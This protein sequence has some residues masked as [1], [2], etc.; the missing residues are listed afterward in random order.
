MSWHFS[1]KLVELCENL[2]SSPELEEESSAESFWAGKPFAPW[3]SMPFAPDDSC[4]GKMRGI[5]H[6]SPFG[7]MFVP[8]TDEYGGAL[9]T[10][11]REV[12]LARTSAPSARGKALTESIA[13]CGERWPESSQRSNPSLCSSKIH[14]TYALADL[15]ES[16][17]TLTAWGT[18][19]RGVCLELTPVALPISES[20]C[21]LLPTPTTRGNEMSPYMLKWPAHRNMKDLLDRLARGDRLPT[22]TAR[23]YGTNRGGAAGR[24]GKVRPSLKKLTGGPWITFREW[25]MGWPIGWTESAPLATDRFHQWLD[26]PGTR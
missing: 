21:G 26:W 3:K 16:S 19:Q 1:R 8:S 22:P 5:C 11:F 15:S 10:W 18:T 2:P 14:H 17:K 4:S 20:A 9:L 23:L 13:D 6:R 7:T 24:N 12:F 25:M